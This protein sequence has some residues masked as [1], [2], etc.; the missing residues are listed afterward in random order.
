MT[1]LALPNNNTA[2]TFFGHRMRIPIK[3]AKI[4]R[5]IS[6]SEIGSMGDEIIKYKL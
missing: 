3:N 6:E 5:A 2:P 1:L 4:I